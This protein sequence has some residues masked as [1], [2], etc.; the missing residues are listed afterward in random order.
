METQLT[1]KEALMQDPVLSDKDIVRDFWT[2]NVC[3]IDVPK[4]GEIGSRAFFEEDEAVRYHYHYHLLPLF[5]SLTH[6]YPG[7]RLL[8]IGCSM[9]ADLLQLARRGFYVTGID[10]TEAGIALAKQRFALYDLPAELRVGDAENLAF[11]DNTFDIVYSHGVLHHTPNIEGAI[12]E[13]FRVLK[14][15]GV[16][17]VMLYHRHSLNFVAHKLLQIPPDGSREDPVPIV[18]T[19]SRD[20]V[21]TLFSEFS[22]VQI[23]VAYLFGRGWRKV[24][25]LIP[26]SLH[27]FLGKHIGWHL[28]IRGVK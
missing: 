10:L 1:H 26:L 6:Q 11:E 20:E 18:R 14:K 28:I 5:D 23:N 17:V 7:G 27:R 16:A 21:R 2:R 9:A 24:N 22:E 13:V 3:Y 8:E 19:Y 12:Q 4:T 25:R 15:G